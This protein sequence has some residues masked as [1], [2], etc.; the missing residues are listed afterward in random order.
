M[1]SKT[2]MNKLHDLEKPLTSLGLF[3]LNLSYLKKDTDDYFY[4]ISKNF[5]TLSQQYRDQEKK[6]YFDEKKLQYNT[7]QKQIIEDNTLND[8]I[9][10]FL[11]DKINEDLIRLDILFLSSTLEKQKEFFQFQE[12]GGQYKIINNCP[13]NN[14]ELQKKIDNL[15][16][17]IYGNSITETISERDECL[18]L[19]SY[20]LRVNHKRITSEEWKLLQTFIDR[21]SDFQQDY[22][23]KYTNPKI[24]KPIWWTIDMQ[25]IMDISEIIRK[26]FYSEIDRWQEKEEWRT[27]YSAFFSSKMRKYPDKKIDS[28]DKIFTV[29]WHEDGTHMIRWDNHFKK[30]FTIPG[31]W[32]ESIEEGMAKLNERLKHSSLDHYTVSPN[33]TFLSTFVAENCDFEDTYTILHI[34]NKLITDPKKYL[35]TEEYEKKVSDKALQSTKR[36]KCYCDRTNPWSNRKDTIYYRWE[37]L[38][39][40]KLQQLPDDISRLNFYNKLMSLKLS[41]EDI[42]SWDFDKFIDWSNIQAPLADK[43]IFQKLKNGK[44]AFND[45]II[46]EDWKT[47]KDKNLLEWDFRT[48]WMK[49]YTFQQKRTI[50]EILNMLQ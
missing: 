43:I 42:V 33:N 40:N 25:S 41:L 50:I 46:W 14:Y 28:L 45:M 1:I 37:K 29:L 3:G 48:L 23:K 7:L 19:L 12:E 5:D 44:W 4:F 15:Q 17:E 27:N 18:W 47:N 9:K 36:A 35:N 2:Y 24:E 20:K 16:K 22:N 13:Q 11:S 21:F 6:H 8:V 26:N 31:I 49:K 32:C 38:L 34:Y 10:R 30:W 39:L